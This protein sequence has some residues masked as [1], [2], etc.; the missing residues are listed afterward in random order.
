MAVFN[1][2]QEDLLMLSEYCIIEQESL[3]QILFHYFFLSSLLQSRVLCYNCAIC[4]RNCADVYRLLDYFTPTHA[5]PHRVKKRSHSFT[6][7]QP[8]NGYIQPKKC[9]T[10][11]H[12]TEKGNAT[13]LTY[14]YVKSIPFLQYQQ[15]SSF[16]KQID[17]FNFFY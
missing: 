7:T 14:I 5:H 2:I 15:M 9:Y 16:L 8:E 11:P 4:K 10:Y 3:Q 12:I 6:H 13:C 1:K 17:L